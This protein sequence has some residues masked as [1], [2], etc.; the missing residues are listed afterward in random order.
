MVKYWVSQPLGG[1]STLYY[2]SVLAWSQYRSV[3]TLHN[4]Y[5][6]T[7]ATQNNRSFVWSCT[8]CTYSHNSIYLASPVGPVFQRLVTSWTIVQN[9]LVRGQVRCRRLVIVVVKRHGDF[10]QPLHQTRRLVI[11]WWFFFLSRVSANDNKNTLCDVFYPNFRNHN[12][13]GTSSNWNID[14]NFPTRDALWD[15]LYKFFCENKKC[16]DKGC[17]SNVNEPFIFMNFKGILKR[18]HP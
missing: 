13:L 15:L 8:K 3:V 17:Y 12:S 2:G 18:V 4:D 9:E 10:L 1:T 16:E 14:V 5:I 11:Q 7:I 6:F